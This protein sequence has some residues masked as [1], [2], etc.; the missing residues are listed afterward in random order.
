M[1]WRHWRAA[2]GRGLL[3]VINPDAHDVAGLDFVRAGINAARK[4]GLT[5]AQVLNTRG[6]SK[7]RQ[8]L[9]TKNPTAGA[10]GSTA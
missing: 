5:A 1:D 9:K 3:C 4:G 10:G 8:Y 6:F 2:A 7:V